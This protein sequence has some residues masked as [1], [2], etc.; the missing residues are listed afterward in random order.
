MLLANKNAVIYGGGGVLSGTIARAFGA[1]GANVFVS[2]RHIDKVQ[3]V[4]NE[5]IAAGGKAEAAVADALDADAVNAYVESVAAKAGSI[6]ISFNLVGIL[7]PP[8]VPMVTLTPN[9]F[10]YPVTNAVKTQFLTSIAAGKI[11]MKQGSGVILS[12]T[13]TAAA[14]VYP[15]LGGCG[16]ALAAMEGFSR[17]LAGELGAYG[18]R[19]VNIRSGGSP[20]SAPFTDIF[21]VLDRETAQG[22]LNKMADD[23]ML[24]KMPPMADIANVAVFLASDMAGKITGT[25]ID[26]TCGTTGALNYKPNYEKKSH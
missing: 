3:K 13:N 10:M 22:I 25:T 7:A 11:M 17:N 15:M 4:A 19:V 20:D 24:K 9:D 12:L 2:G 1:A 23:T 14:T 21:K 6:D 18:V 5:I 8:N 26:V 16:T